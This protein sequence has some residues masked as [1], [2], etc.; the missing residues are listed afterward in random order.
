MSQIH[1]REQNEEI[2]VD[3]PMGRTLLDAS[4]RSGIPHYHACNGR[5]RCT[6]C[7]VWVLDGLNALNPRTD[8]EKRVAHQKH[9]PPEIRL[10][11]Q[12][13]IFGDVTVKRLV[14]DDDDMDLVFLE[15]DA[16]RP[17]EMRPIAVMACHTGSFNQIIYNHLPYDALHL[18]NRYYK[19]LAEA[20][21]LNQGHVER[22]RD[23]GLIGLFG[24]ENEDAAANCLDAAR[25]GLRMAARLRDL[26]EYARHHFGCAFSLRVGLHYGPVLVGEVW[27]PQQWQMM[28]LGK[29]VETAREIAAVV[30]SDRETAIIASAQFLEHVE[31]KLR[32]GAAVPDSPNGPLRPVYDF[33][34][35]DMAYW[36]QLSLEEIGDN[37]DLVSAMFYDRLFE[38]DPTL[39]DLFAGVNMR[40]QRKM[41]MNMLTFA[42]H[43]LSQQDKV[44]PALHA[45]GKR[46]QEYGVQPEA[47]ATAG[48]AL[49]DVLR[50]YFGDKFSPE[51]QLGWL[52][53]YATIVQMINEPPPNPNDAPSRVSTWETGHILQKL[54]SYFPWELIQ[55]IDAGGRIEGE[56]RQVTV[57]FADISGFTA[58][59]ERLDPELVANLVNEALQEMA[60]AVYQ[61]G[62]FVDK[63][64]GDAV[65]ALFGAPHSHEDDPERA[66]HCALAMQE[67]L[68]AFNDRWFETMG[69]RLTLHTGINT[70]PV[71]AGS[72]GSDLRMAYT[73]IGDTVN[74]AARLENLAKPGQILV[75]QSAYRLTAEAFAFQQLEPVVVKGKREPLR[76]YAL[77]RPAK[78]TNDQ[79]TK[80]LFD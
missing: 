20:I 7:R 37:A 16:A 10:A 59:S 69:E 64:I 75:G 17:A 26:N 51:I 62:G 55:Q 27:H 41:L 18:L 53:S 25:A 77:R 11:C 71:I 39:R 78:T 29:T 79:T 57:V 63:F 46:H 44:W 3:Q 72:V 24:L 43:G 2:V 52:Q 38:L 8:A 49:I 33:R 70:G 34:E 13:Q 19:E 80:R 74:T 56:R 47:Y 30:T 23:G 73:V 61:Y 54:Q 42:V 5:A 45:L 6:T 22:Y 21:T 15:N 28:A 67:R 58:L 76:V 9:W 4:L 35:H 36:A 60:A 50:Q 32:L 40:V 14:V 31:D 1:F 66:L 48:K 65:M 68:N 12:A